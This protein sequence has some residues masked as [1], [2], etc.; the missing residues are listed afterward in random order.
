M[1]NICDYLLLLRG[2]K[3]LVAAYLLFV[4][5]YADFKL[6]SHRVWAWQIL[7]MHKIYKDVILGISSPFHWMSVGCWQRPCC[8]NQP[9]AEIPPTPGVVIASWLGI[10]PSKSAPTGE[11]PTSLVAATMAQICKVS[12]P[13]PQYPNAACATGGGVLQPAF[14]FPLVFARELDVRGIGK[15]VQPMDLR[16]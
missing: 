3:C 12:A 10:W 13:I 8:T 7:R 2:L 11:P 6:S 1:S 4:F 16:R 15:H 14:C 9:E 5:S